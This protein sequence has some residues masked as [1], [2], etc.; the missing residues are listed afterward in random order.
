MKLNNSMTNGETHEL[1]KY[2]ELYGTFQR[3]VSQDLRLIA[4]TST[5]SKGIYIY[6]NK[7]FN[8]SE[9]GFISIKL[10]EKI[11]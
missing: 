5:D 2:S 11:K 9:I 4:S 1:N 6:F 7:S 3:M 8:L 10:G